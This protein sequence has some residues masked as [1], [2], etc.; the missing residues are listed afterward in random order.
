MKKLLLYL[1][2]L[3]PTTMYVFLKKIPF[4]S[5]ERDIST[6]H[7]CLVVV[8]SLHDRIHKFLF[9]EKLQVFVKTKGLFFGGWCCVVKFLI[10]CAWSQWSYFV[11]HYVGFN[12]TRNY[13]Y[14]RY[15]D[16]NINGNY[17]YMIYMEDE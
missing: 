12:T 9:C 4:S 3:S 17:Y 15:V 8:G 14:I 1:P 13:Y 11:S 7:P 16:F 5:H 2:I 6:C 10:R